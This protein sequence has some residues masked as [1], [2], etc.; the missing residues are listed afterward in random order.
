MTVLLSWN[1]AGRVRRLPEQIECVLG[2]SADVICLQE[3]TSTTQPLWETKLR[4]RGW[5]HVC[6]AQPDK[7][8][9]RALCVMTAARSPLEQEAI[10]GLP[11]P[12]RV[13]AT[14]IDGIE[15]V[16]VHSPISSS[17]DLAK[18][19]THE[20][21]HAHLAARDKPGV[22]CGDLNTPRR[23]FPD[24][25]I[26]TFA[27]NQYGKLEPERGERWDA[28]ELAL[29]K[30]LEPYGWRDAFRACH[31]PEE[32][33]LSWAW[34]RWKGGYRLDHLVVSDQISVSRVAYVHSWRTDGLSD[35]SALIAT[36]DGTV[37]CPTPHLPKAEAR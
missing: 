15:Y 20:V 9:H 35:H 24:G 23:E 7:P 14:R 1:V 37:I 25:R 10:A 16:N 36:L 13:L 31:G 17:A 22:L 32:R 6:V 27:R 2:M 11:W 21:V 5:E 26:W 4:E 19:L 33:E 8:K 28:A 18:V 34:A 12:E 30:G 29:I 3:V